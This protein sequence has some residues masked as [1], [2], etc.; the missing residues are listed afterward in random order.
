MPLAILMGR[1]SKSLAIIWSEPGCTVGKAIADEAIG[2]ID[3]I[4]V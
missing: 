2:D 1:A 4:K 3:E